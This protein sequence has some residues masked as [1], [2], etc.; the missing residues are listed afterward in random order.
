MDKVCHG[1]GL[2]WERLV[3]NKVCRGKDL[4]VF[5]WVYGV[6]G[7]SFLEWVCCGQGLSCGWFVCLG[8]VFRGQ[9]L[10]VAQISVRLTTGFSLERWG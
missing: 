2:L 3:V 6:V 5:G 7:V 8:M 9:S 10:S 4:S 1:Q